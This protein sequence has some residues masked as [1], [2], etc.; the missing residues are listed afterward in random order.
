MLAAS[1]RL[2]VTRSWAMAAAW[3]RAASTTAPWEQYS[4]PSMKTAIPGPKSKA[5]LGEVRACARQPAWR[6]AV[7]LTRA[8]PWLFLCFSLSRSLL[9]SLVPRSA[10]QLDRY[11]DTRTMHFLANFSESSGNYVKDAD[12]NVLLDVLCQI[13]SIPVGYSNPALLKAAKSDEMAVALMNRPALGIMPD[14]NWADMIKKTFMKIAPLGM[15]QVWS[16]MCGSC[17]N[18]NALKSAMMHYRHK[19]RNGAPFTAEELSSVMLNKAP[20]SAKLSVLSFTSSFHGRTF[21]SLSCTRSKAIHKL[22]IPAYDWPVAPFPALKY[23]LDAYA[24]ENRREEDRCLEQVQVLI[25]QWRQRGNPVAAVIVEPIQGEGGDNTASPRFFRELQQIT[26]ALGAALVVDEVQTGGGA[27][28]RMWAHEAWELPTPPD[29]VTFSKKLQA[30]GFF[31]LAE[32]R[33][34][35]GYRLFNTWCVVRAR[36]AWLC[37][38]AA[39]RRCVVRPANVVLHVC[40]LVAWACGLCSSRRL[41]GVL[42]FSALFR[43]LLCSAGWAIPRVPSSWTPSFAMSTSTSCFRPCSAWAPRCCAA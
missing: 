31:H 9:P 11:Q 10:A 23:P 37:A 34:S 36:A 7:S 1:A 33:P 17:A 30:A 43:S 6:E 4:K 27:T 35:E 18:E 41:R 14:Q 2:G 13:S 40:M 3:V 38:S 16:A 28:G 20:G 25:E 29:Y 19:E 12:G 26:K 32:S 39:M 15:S 42:C 8:R 5:L 24:T 21:G 22:D